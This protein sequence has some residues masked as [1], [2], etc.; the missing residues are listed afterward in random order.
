MN[1][2]KFYIKALQ[3]ISFKAFSIVAYILLFIF[4][5]LS[6]LRLTELE[7]NDIFDK[8]ST[9]NIATGKVSKFI[10]YF[11]VELPSILNTIQYLCLCLI[12]LGLIL[13]IFSFFG[14]IILQK[15]SCVLSFVGF[16]ASLFLAI[17]FGMIAGE[18]NSSDFFDVLSIELTSFILYAQPIIFLLGTIFVYAYIKMPKYRLEEG[19][20]F[21]TFLA[22]LD[23][24]C[25][26]RTF[27]SY[28]NTEDLFRLRVQLKKKKYATLEE[29]KSLKKNKIKKKKAKKPKRPTRRPKT[30]EEI[31]K[32]QK[33]LTPLEIALAKREHAEA[34]A[35]TK[36]EQDNKSIFNKDYDPDEVHDMADDIE[37]LEYEPK[38][39]KT[40]KTAVKESPALKIARQRAM[41]AEQ[42]A[43]KK[44]DMN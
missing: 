9:Y 31:E 42:I 25:F 13:L 44:R 5:R 10:E 28:D 6:V 11:G 7:F 8:F 21:A 33:K 4:Q 15:I 36:A 18:L 24:R 26:F 19:R 37:Y 41:H 16:A 17:Y 35:N 30:A 23:P 32:L 20:F 2:E 3:S 38:K 43:N 22:A 29:P 1:T 39:I 12:I 40:R 27:K 34:I 14:N